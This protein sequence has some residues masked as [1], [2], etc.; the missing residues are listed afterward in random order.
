MVKGIKNPSKRLKGFLFHF[1]PADQ[2]IPEYALISISDIASR[3]NALCYPADLYVVN[4][5]HIQK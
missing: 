5:S 1:Y 3:L 4:R 2:G